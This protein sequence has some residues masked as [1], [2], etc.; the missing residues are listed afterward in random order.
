M[1][2]LFG[3][4]R[5]TA[6][7][8]DIGSGAVKAVQLCGREGAWQIAAVAVAPRRDP[9]APLNGA[10]VQRIVDLLA[11]QGFTGTN[12]VAAVPG[13]HV[14]GG[15]VELSSAQAG[16]PVEQ[17]ARR[18]LAA[19]HRLEASDLEIACWPLPASGRSRESSRMMATGCTTT[20]ATAFL[21]LLEGAGLTVLVLETPATALARICEHSGAGAGQL[22]AVLD[23]GWSAATLVLLCRG[24]VIYE[25]RLPEVGLGKL[26]QMLSTTL[27]VEPAI[28]EYLVREVGL[29]EASRD[30]IDRAVLEDLHAALRDH[31][32]DLSRELSVSFSYATHQYPD[33]GVDRLALVG[34]GA[35]MPGLADMLAGPTGVAVAPLSTPGADAN[36]SSLCMAMG[37]ALHEEGR[38]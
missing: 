4:S 5:R 7:G 17:V 9:A 23:L 26:C 24:A 15:I 25:R 32:Q 12:V 29:G 31:Y 1:M 19:M 20:E 3:K 22:M 34:G 2:A 27:E 16:E 35:T 37:L 33:S 18:E 28:I 21:D 14:R 13:H 10:D 38:R 30:V 11:R 8:L 6:I 36:S